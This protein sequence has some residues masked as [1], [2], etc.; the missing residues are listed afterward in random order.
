VK[1]ELQL[2]NMLVVVEPRAIPRR[3]AE[4]PSTHAGMD[5]RTEAALGNLAMSI[6][7]DLRS[8][9][10]AIHSGAEMLSRS[11]FP[12]QQVR[13]LASNMYNAAVRMQELLQ[14]YV[15]LC[16]TG[17][18]QL[19]P[20]DLRSL[21]T[22]AVNRIAPVAEAQ[23]VAIVQDVC[24]DLAAIVDRGRIGSVLTNLLTNALEAMP[25]GGLIQIT[26]MA[27]GRSVI[28][29]VRDTGPGVAPEVRDR[30]FEPFVTRKSNGLG[31]GLSQARQIVMDHGGEMWLESSS[32]D[33]ACF[34]F[35]LPAL[36]PERLR[37][38]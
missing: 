22:H 18:S 8:P 3:K 37:A 15:D 7:H 16:R 20:S 4:P 28:I 34:A 31:L 25:A 24:A 30:L 6:V 29:K 36:Q 17:Q 2:K 21:V 12:E 11:Q 1:K 23:S 19:R 33:G 26:A 13:R 32:R 14:D 38:G 5:P 35:S 9:L 10:A 27:A